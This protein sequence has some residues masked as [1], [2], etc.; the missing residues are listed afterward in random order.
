MYCDADYAGDKETRRS[1]SGMIVMMNGGSIS[2]SSRLQQLVALSSAESE[3]YAVAD[4]VK[5][6]LQV[7]L[8]CEDCGLRKHGEPMTAWEDNAVAIHLGH[9]LRGNNEQKHFAVRLRFLWRHIQCKNI[10]FAKVDTKE[11]LA[12][13]F[14]KQLLGPALINF[15]NKVL[16]S[17][18]GH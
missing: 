1:T 2:W 15:R 7:K 3:I 10:E 16:K 14:I 5:E 6:A 9:V 13:A 18:K 4:S 17:N 11:Q 8:M 12:D